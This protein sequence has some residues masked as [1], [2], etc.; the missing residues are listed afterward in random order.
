VA[1]DLAVEDRFFL[2]PPVLQTDLFPYTCSADVGIVS[3][4][5]TCRNNYYCAPNKLYEYSA[6]GLPMV[7]SD[8]PPVRAYLEDNKVGRVFEADNVDSLV[9]AIEAV[10][11]DEVAFQEFRDHCFEAASAFTWE[12]QSEVAL[13]QMYT[14]I[15]KDESA[16]G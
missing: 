5:N 16:D 13:R 9:A 11:G 12:N 6:A 15:E 8:L 1:E 2:L 14:K 10:C 3:Y 4:Q 7:G